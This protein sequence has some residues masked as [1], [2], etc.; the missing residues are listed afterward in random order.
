MTLFTPRHSLPY[1][2]AGDGVKATRA[3]IQTM[4]ELVDTKLTRESS[5][6]AVLGR[7]RGLATYEENGPNLAGYI[8][9]QTNMNSSDYMTRFHITGYC[10][11]PNNNLIDLQIGFYMFNDTNMYNY[12]AKNNGT[13]RFS[14]IQIVKRTSD[15]KIAI[16]LLPASTDNAGQWNYPKLFVDVIVGSNAPSVAEMT[17]WSMSRVANLSAYTIKRVVPSGRPYMRSTLTTAESTPNGSWYSL[18]NWTQQYSHPLITW[19]GTST[20]T[21]AQGG[22]YR[23]DASAMWRPDGGYTG[24]RGIQVIVGASAVMG[25]YAS[26]KTDDYASSS[27]SDTIPLSPGSTVVVQVLQNSGAAVTIHPGYWTKIAITR[28]D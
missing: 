8:V 20:W 1:A 22:L 6:S 4:T 26:G 27:V 15:G 5:M 23:I 10:Y 25:N 24:V 16:A 14:D 28:A 3:T 7:W 17:G 21:V 19:S 13:M 18:I 9:I 2:E 11:I 12:E